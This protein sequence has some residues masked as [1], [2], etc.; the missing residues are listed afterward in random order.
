MWSGSGGPTCVES[1]GRREAVEGSSRWT[2]ERFSDDDESVR[3][4][5]S[6]TG[7]SAQPGWRQADRLDAGWVVD[8]T[9]PQP[10]E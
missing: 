2:P 1:G 8:C 5:D 10:G 4:I 9:G 3:S 6:F 7:E